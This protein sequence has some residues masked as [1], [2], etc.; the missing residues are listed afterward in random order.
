[1]GFLMLY[2]EEPDM[3][4]YFLIHGYRYYHHKEIVFSIVVEVDFH[5]IPG[6]TNSHL[7]NI[8]TSSDEIDE[9]GDTSCI[10]NLGSNRWPRR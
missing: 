9:V 7:I 3:H 8:K 10:D 6:Y 2:C 5:T 4:L 1:M